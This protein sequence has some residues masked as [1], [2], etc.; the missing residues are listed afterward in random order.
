MFKSP[1]LSQVFGLK[2]KAAFVTGGGSGIGYAIAECLVTNGAKEALDKVVHELSQR[3]LT[4]IPIVVDMT[5]RDNIIAAKKVVGDADGVGP[6]SESLGQ[7]DASKHVDLETLGTALFNN[8]TSEQWAKLYEIN[9]FA[10][11]FVTTAFLGL[12]AR[13]STNYSSVAINTTSISGITKLAQ[14]HFVYNNSKAAAAHLTRT[15][16]TV[17]ELK[18]IPVRVSAIAPSAFPS[19]MTHN[20]IE[21]ARTVNEVG[22]SITPIPAGRAGKPRG[23][24][25]MAIHL[26]SPAGYYTNGQKILVDGGYITVN[27]PT[28]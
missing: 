28:K 18:N 12:L 2:G 1:N 4:V 19:E 23:I 16:A 14:R 5:D 8:E 13:D 26:A 9:T 3:N 22:N 25:G 11:Y 20:A 10:M 6:V 7:K 15:M 27:P 21:S 24:A 17:F